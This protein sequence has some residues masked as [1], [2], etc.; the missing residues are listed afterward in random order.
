VDVWRRVLLC[1]L[2]CDPKMHHW[3]AVDS[4]VHERVGPRFTS[5]IRTTKFGDDFAS[6]K[7]HT[8]DP[9]DQFIYGG[10]RS[11][12]RTVIPARSRS[13]R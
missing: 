5:S 9:T 2:G 1:P 11:A 12:R 13:S 10:S 8:N 3:P 6:S 7:L 4:S